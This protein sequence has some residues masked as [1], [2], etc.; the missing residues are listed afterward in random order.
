M[1]T[2][3][4]LDVDGAAIYLKLSRFTV[5]QKAREGVLPAAKIGRVWRFRKADLDAWLVAGGTLSAEDRYLARELAR[6]A[7]D[8]GNAQPIPWEQVKR[9][10]GL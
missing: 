6:R 3:E 10:L 5:R 9:E 4:V 7:A 2:A 1:A 8:P